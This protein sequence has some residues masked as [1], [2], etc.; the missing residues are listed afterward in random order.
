MRL[1]TSSAVVALGVVAVWMT[2]T[3]VNQAQ[4]AASSNP[5]FG[6]KVGV[7]DL[8]F[9]FDQF[10][11][12]QVLNRKMEAYRKKV[13]QEADVKQQALQSD[14]A[15]LDSF[16][17]D[18]S[19]YY[20]RNEEFKK[21]VIEYRVWEGLTRDRITESYRW[22]I[23]RTYQMITDEVASVAKAEG[24]QLVLTKDRLKTDVQDVK[25]LLARIINRKVVYAD[26]RVDM[27][28]KVLSSLNAAFQKAGGPDTVE[29]LK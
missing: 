11:Q 15:V 17:K 8:E 10:E 2:A 27:T 1:R 19:D 13:A 25:E 29:F 18:S 14:Q 12:T 23:E 24:V 16:A 5:Q 26:A 7:I 20:K 9:V 28:E 6:T 22:W 4:P 21:K 3:T